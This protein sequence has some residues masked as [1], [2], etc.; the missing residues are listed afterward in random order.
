MKPLLTLFLA[1]T[2]VSYALEAEACSIDEAY[3]TAAKLT[4][5]LNRLEKSDV[6]QAIAVN[7]KVMARVRE[8]SRELDFTV[9]DPLTFDET[10]ENIDKLCIINAEALRVF[11]EEKSRKQLAE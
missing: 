6:F 7:E 3:D 5:G 9:T 4:L 2:I 8:L 1:S 11:E 10:P